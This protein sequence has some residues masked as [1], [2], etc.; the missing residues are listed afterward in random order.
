MNQLEKYNEFEASLVEIENACNFLPDVSTPEGYEKSKR[1]GLDGRKV[2][3]AIDDKRLQMKKEAEVVANEIHETGKALCKRVQ[4]A[5]KPHQEAYKE[6]DA[7]IKRKKEAVEA[8]ITADIAAFME[9]VNTAYDLSADEI[10]DLIAK[11][12][13]NPMEFGNRTIEAGESRTRAI[14]QLKGMQASKI[15]AEQ[16]A[17]DL[18]EQ[19]AELDRQQE[20]QRKAQ[21][22]INEQNRIEQENLAAERQAQQEE[23]RKAQEEQRVKAAEEAAAQAERNRIEQA[24]AAEKAAAEKKAANK[25]HRKSINNAALNDLTAAGFS[26]ED[27]KRIIELV[28]QGKISNITINY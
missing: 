2:D 21:E 13:S 20:E 27:G 6:H 24:A 9:S 15:M 28:A 14:T 7:E 5:Y 10:G 25:A 1:I 23:Q 3:K 12:E 17:K 11:H 8:K 16:Q 18:A 4:D 22:I 26:D 19:Q